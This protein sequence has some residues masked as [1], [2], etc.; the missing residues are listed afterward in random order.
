M[1]TIT[2]RTEDLQQGLISHEASEFTSTARSISAV[3]DAT[4]AI[5][6]K[7]AHICPAEQ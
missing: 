6:R 3:A 4:L 7:E 1:E 2:W 5:C